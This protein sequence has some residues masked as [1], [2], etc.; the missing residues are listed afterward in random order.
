MESHLLAMIP[1][2]KP[3]DDSPPGVPLDYF[4]FT[5]FDYDTVYH[6]FRELTFLSLSLYNHKHNAI[7]VYLT[8]FKHSV[9]L[10]EELNLLNQV[11][12]LD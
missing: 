2:L 4:G 9:V 7:T 8:I 12:T 11:R 3:L 5:R 6:H 1:P 10:R